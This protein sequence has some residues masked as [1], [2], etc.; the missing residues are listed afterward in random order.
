[1]R[2][3]RGTASARRCH[4]CM[5]RAVGTS[6]GSPELGL[7]TSKT[8]TICQRPCWTY[9]NHAQRHELPKSQALKLTQQSTKTTGAMYEAHHRQLRLVAGDYSNIKLRRRNR[10]C[11]GTMV[12]S[13][14]DSYFPA[15]ALDLL[16]L[17]WEEGGGVIMHYDA[18]KYKRA[19]GTPTA[20]FAS[21][22]PANCQ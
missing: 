1:M 17:A 20:Q 2:K 7:T 4:Y 5:R 14:L 21:V 8:T 18:W 16:Q 3:P 10:L 6:A 12:L 22:P 9:C 11:S 19:N 15:L 13:N